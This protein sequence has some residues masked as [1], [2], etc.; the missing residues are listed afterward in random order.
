MAR[1]ARL[2]RPAVCHQLLHATAGTRLEHLL[3][4]AAINRRCC[5]TGSPSAGGAYIIEEWTPGDHISLVKNPNYFRSAEGL[6]AFDRLTFRFVAGDEALRALLAGECDVVDKSALGEAQAPA[7]A[8]ME[9]QVAYENGAAWEHLDFNL[10]PL[11]P[12]RASRCGD[13][14]TAKSCARQSPRASTARQS[15][16]LCFQDS[17]RSPNS[18]VPDNHPLHNPDVHQYSYDPQ[19][20]STALTALGWVDNDGNPTDAAQRPGSRRYPGWHA[21]TN[22]LPDHR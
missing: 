13:L 6:P 16:R 8:E 17:R 2:S 22:P 10:S 21:A 11:T 12:D 4:A 9:V 15:P 18:Y 14:R 3:A 19:A 1:R 5:L 20:A 7:L